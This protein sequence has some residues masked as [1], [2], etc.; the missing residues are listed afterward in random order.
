M[1]KQRVIIFMLNSAEH[2]IVP[3]GILTFMSRKIAYYAYLSLKNA[4]FLDIF[5]LMSI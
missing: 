1:E 4:G 3:A 5:I 2:E